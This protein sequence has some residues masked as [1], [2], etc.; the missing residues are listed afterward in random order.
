M[1]DRMR[2]GRPGREPSLMAAGYRYAWKVQ[3]RDRDEIRHYVADAVFALI[4]GFNYG[5]T[6]DMV[7]WA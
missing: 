6:P 1:R 3:M 2:D 5:M 7:V 4:M